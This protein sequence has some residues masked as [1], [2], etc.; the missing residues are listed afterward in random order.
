MT[1]SFKAP[2]QLSHNSS[3]GKLSLQIDYSKAFE[4]NNPVNFLDSLGFNPTKGIAALVNAANASRL[5][6]TGLLKVTGAAG[7]L[8]TGVGAP[9]SAVIAAWGFYNIR[10]AMVA[11]ERGLTLWNETF[12][13][14]WSDAS[15]KILLGVLPHGE[16]YDDPWEPSFKEFWLDYKIK[17]W[18]ESISEIGTIS[19]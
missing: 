15:W 1:L 16:K 5:Y 6:G 12:N 4:A 14:S 3:N 10:G 2:S 18:W 9:G 19:P 13:Q 7:L 11:Q 8:T 17:S